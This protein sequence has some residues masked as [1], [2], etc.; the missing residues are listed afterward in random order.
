MLVTMTLIGTMTMVAF[1]YFLSGAEGREA[2]TT[3]VL[4]SELGHANKMYALDHGGVYTSGV[5]TAEC[6]KETCP[7]SKG[8]ADACN[9]ISCKVIPSENWD[10]LGWLVR[11]HDPANGYNCRMGAVACAWR[12]NGLNCPDCPKSTR[13]DPYQNWGYAIDGSEK[14]TAEGE[15]PEFGTKGGN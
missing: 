12:K 1:H 13:K 8:A 7:S 11:A 6:D 9:L 14:M 3:S 2:Q 10:T 5:L 4:L 15:A